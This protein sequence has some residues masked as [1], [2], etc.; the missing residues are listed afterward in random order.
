ME[1]AVLGDSVAWG[2][3]LVN[4]HKYSYLVAEHLGEQ[5]IVQAH[6]G[7]I[8]GADY[9]GDLVTA[10]PEVPEH[11]PTIL[12]QIDKIS[13]PT[14]VDLVLLNGGINDIGVPTI[15]NPS[16]KNSALQADIEKF[17]HVDMKRLLKKAVNTFTNDTCRFVVTGYY[18]I[19]SSKSDPVE[20]EVDYLEKLLELHCLTIPTHFDRDPIVSHIVSLTEQFWNQS[21]DQLSKAVA[22]TNSEMRLGNRIIFVPSPFTKENALFAGDP[23]LFGFNADLSPQDEVITERADACN[24]HYS[25]PFDFAQREVCH[26]ASVGHPNVAGAK[27]IATAILNSLGS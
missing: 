8:I 15:L 23:W 1:I 13:N 2:Q 5:P 10:D 14:D 3:G 9:N 20:V 27:A 4:E 19:L 24:Y 26:Y 16:I 17:C 22:E 18:P 25:D 11:A 21:N 12:S 7:A 6:S